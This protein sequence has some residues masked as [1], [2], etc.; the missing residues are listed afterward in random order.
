MIRIHWIAGLFLPFLVGFAAEARD[1]IETRGVIDVGSSNTKIRVAK[2][3]VCLQK[4]EAVIFQSQEKVG[5]AAD[6]GAQ[7]AAGKPEVLSDSIQAEGLSAMD[8]LLQSAR[9]VEA[10][11]KFLGIATSAFRQASNG[12]T[13]LD[14][15]AKKT[16]V[17][18]SILAQEV[19]GRLGFIG[20]MQASIK[21]DAKH[22]LV[23]DIGGG[24]Q[25][26]TWMD[27]EERLAT[28]KLEDAAS[29]RMRT[30]L[31]REVKKEEPSVKSPNPVGAENLPAALKRAEELV[32]GVT[33][34][35]ERIQEV[36]GVGGV[37]SASV[38]RMTGKQGGFTADEISAAMK[39][40]ALRTDSE[41]NSSFS[42]PDKYV[43][44]SVS[45]LIL[46]SGAMKKLGFKSI[47]VSTFGTTEGALVYPELW[48]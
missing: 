39:T 37:L 16:G 34:P 43:E 41:I 18:F 33:L 44:T 31:I 3:D 9:K 40:Y 46:V 7:K 36:I 24:S 47:R 21:K 12:R 23:W 2:V 38:P 17:P 48:K 19:E 26:F 32:A 29:D 10:K 11:T 22:T 13:V 27:E 45:N 6:L 42:S 25:Q 8:R 14:A 1:C 5:Y 30:I 20:G 4:I 35:S 15:Y 28:A